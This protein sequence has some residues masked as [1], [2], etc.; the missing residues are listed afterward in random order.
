MLEKNLP[1]YRCPRC[2]GALRLLARVEA[3]D[4]DSGADSGAQSDAQEIRSGELA[5]ADPA[6]AAL[7]AFPIERGMVYLLP[8]EARVSDVKR[9]ERDGWARIA[10]EHNALETRDR[11]LMELPFVDPA[12]LD[13]AEE[14]SEHWRQAA[15]TF[16][17]AMAMM[18]GG[19]ADLRGKRALEVGA[20]IGWGARRLAEAGADVVATDFNADPDCGLGKAGFFIERGSPH[21]ERLVA[22]AEFM[23]LADASFDIVFCCATIHHFEKPTALLAEIARVLKPGGAF[24]AINEAFRPALIRSA[25]AQLSLSKQTLDHLEFGINEQVFTHGEYRRFFEAAGLR[26]RAVHPRW[27][28]A[29]G[30]GANAAANG[31]DGI[32]AAAVNGGGAR[33][34][35][36]PGIGLRGD[37]SISDAGRS[38]A[39]RAFNALGLARALRLPP[40]Q[41]AARA[42]LFNFTESY[43]VLVGEKPARP[44]K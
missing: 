23:P 9:R 15:M 30:P 3:F 1:L 18:L 19:A 44:E 4:A 5:C 28:A 35:V 13:G 16:P 37:F 41:A 34:R 21:F 10:R 26:F 32:N 40:V 31:A 29:P 43:R 11:V 12:G 33:L 8:D 7:G 39:R 27:D 2:G 25:R 24:Y 36:E 38:R 42:A 14:A 17:V 22:D 6:C 20:S